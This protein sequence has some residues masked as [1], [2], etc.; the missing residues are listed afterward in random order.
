MVR[1]MYRTQNCNGI[2][3]KI[4]E[5]CDRLVKSDV[6]YRFVID[7]GLVESRFVNAV[8]FLHVSVGLRVYRNENEITN[9]FELIFVDKPIN[10]N[11]IGNH[12]CLNLTGLFA[13]LIQKQA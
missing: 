3:R 11:F 1:Q 13:N 7:Y 10:P 5:A 12:Q 2:I 4:N 8:R 6:K 9:F